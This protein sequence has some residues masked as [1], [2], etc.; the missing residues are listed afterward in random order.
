M[1]TVCMRVFWLMVLMGLSIFLPVTSGAVADGDRDASKQSLPEETAGEEKMALS[2]PEFIRLVREKNVQI[3]YQAAQ[4]AISREAVSGAK[5]IFEPAFVG[6]YTKEEINRQNTVQEAVSQGFNPEFEEK[7]YNYQ[8]GVEGLVP[9]GGRLWLGYSQRDFSNNL[10]QQY[11]VDGESRTVVEANLTQPLL[12][13]GGIDTTMAGIKVAEADADIEF[14]TYRNQMMQVIADAISSYWD[15]HITR[16]K[17]DVIDVSVNLAAKLLSHNRVRVATGKMAET[18]VLEAE[19]GLAVRKSLRSEA[20]QQIVLAT[21]SVRSLFSVS[22]A[23]N[24]LPIEPTDRIEVK[25]LETDFEKSLVKAFKL[26]P[27]YISSRKKVERE[28]I[29]VVYAKNQRWPQLDLKGSYGLNGLAVSSTDSIDETLTQKHPN[30]SL[31][32]ELRIPLGGDIKGRSELEASRQRER[33]ALIE[34]KAVE[35]SLANNTDTAIRG[36]NSAL[37]QLKQYIRVIDFNERLLKAEVARF[38][39]GKSNSRLVLEKE[40]NLLQA[41]EARLESLLKYKKA[42]LGLELTEGTLL[43]NNGIEIMEVDL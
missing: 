39:A 15:L 33:Q 31:G 34:L 17:Y 40:G 28:D 42:L 4:F 20:Q 24:H 11:G 10:E 43:L 32:L 14:Q 8:G 29:R 22:V 18:E 1:K 19:A 25:P 5:A 35:I 13:D 21:N 7:S 23:D 12:K 9:T 27:E 30:W 37:D 41:K 2:L 6:S 26:R 36:V 3:S 38:R 16:E